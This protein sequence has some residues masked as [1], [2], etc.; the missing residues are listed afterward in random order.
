MK[1]GPVRAD[2][3][4]HRGSAVGP[5]GNSYGV[6]PAPMGANLQPVVSHHSI[7]FQSHS[8]AEVD[9]EGESTVIMAVGL[10]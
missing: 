9:R 8:S 7:D 5:V 2:D 10:L 4:M 1:L 6:A 3:F